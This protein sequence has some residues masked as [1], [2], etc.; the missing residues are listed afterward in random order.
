[1]GLTEVVK[2]EYISEKKKSKKFVF[3]YSF[4]VVFGVASVEDNLRTLHAL[5]RI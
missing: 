4:E 2:F 1:M 5:L 3:F